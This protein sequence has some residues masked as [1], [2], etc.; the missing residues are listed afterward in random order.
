MK[1]SWYLR[2]NKGTNLGPSVSKT[3]TVVKNSMVMVTILFSLSKME[4]SSTNIILKTKLSFTNSVM[5]TAFVSEEDSIN[6]VLLF[7]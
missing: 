4:V 5:K 7:T 3:G 2:T 6:L 1:Q